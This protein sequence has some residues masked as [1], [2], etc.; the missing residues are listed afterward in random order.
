MLPTCLR[1]ITTNDAVCQRFTLWRKK[2]SSSKL[3]QTGLDSVQLNIQ[4]DD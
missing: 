4:L 1:E 3:F 2:K